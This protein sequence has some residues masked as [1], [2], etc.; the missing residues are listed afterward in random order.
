MASSHL[1]GG[2]LLW[3]M[4]LPAAGHD[5]GVFFPTWLFRVGDRGVTCLPVLHYRWS[6]VEA[7]STVRHV[8]RPRRVRGLGTCGS[9]VPQSLTSRGLDHSSRA[10]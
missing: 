8:C 6:V 3:F 1:G 5:P 4:D 2:L 9:G 7:A 10:R